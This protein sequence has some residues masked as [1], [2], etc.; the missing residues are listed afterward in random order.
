MPFNRLV[1]A[2]M[3]IF[4][5]S[6]Y[7]IIFT[8]SFILSMLVLLTVCVWQV[9]GSIN[10]SSFISICNWCCNKKCS[11]IKKLYFFFFLFNWST[12][13][14]VTRSVLN[15]SI[16]FDVFYHIQS[17]RVFR[18]KKLRHV[19][20]LLHSNRPESSGLSIYTVF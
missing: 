19:F 3:R 6:I 15:P 9:I 8:C 10:W 7:Y 20:I 12:G 2:I 11:I 5:M 14:I 1:R 4:C 13:G 18:E 16:D 17:V